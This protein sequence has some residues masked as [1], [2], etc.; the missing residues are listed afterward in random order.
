MSRNPGVA[1]RLT[2]RG[3]R[4]TKWKKGKGNL[5]YIPVGYTFKEINNKICPKCGYN[6][7]DSSNSKEQIKYEIEFIKKNGMCSGCYNE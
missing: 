5:S 3:S 4:P 6:P 7:N 1:F 2:V